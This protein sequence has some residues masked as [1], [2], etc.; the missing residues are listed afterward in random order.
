MYDQSG[1]RGSKVKYWLARFLTLTKITRVARKLHGRRGRFVVTLHGILKRR[2]SNLAS[3]VQAGFTV[4]ELHQILHWLELNFRLLTPLEFFES[5]APGVLLTFDDGKA[6]NYTNALPVLVQH[7]APAVFFVSTQ[8]VLDSRAWQPVTARRACFQWNNPAD[9]PD[10]WAWELL[11]GMTPQQVADCARH[12]L[13]TV[14][15]HTVTHPF[16]TRCEPQVLEHELVSSRQQLELMTGTPVDLFAYPTGDYDRRV[17]EAVQRAGYR[18]AFA[19]NS[20]RLGAVRY[21]IPRVDLNSAK[22]Y[23]LEAKL[24]GLH[25]CPIGRLA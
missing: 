14:G 6:N 13:I 18:Y 1:L 10:E 2:Y 21:E 15:S 22:P 3:E 11:N 9:V 24:S 8:H 17:I 19:C 20:K 23:Y 5:D 25:Q 7:N 4:E 12:P 16:L